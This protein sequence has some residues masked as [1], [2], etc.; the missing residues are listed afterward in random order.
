[1]LLEGAVR[2]RR[3]DGGFTDLATGLPGANSIAFTQD[4]KRLFMGQVFMGE[5]LWEIHMTGVPSDWSPNI[6]TDSTLFS[7]G[8]KG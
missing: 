6:R 3:V 1:M 7:S 4:G 5:G 8:R 2:M